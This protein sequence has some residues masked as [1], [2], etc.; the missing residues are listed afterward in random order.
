MR[1]K[2]LALVA[3][4]ATLLV[5]VALISLAR[6]GVVVNNH[7]VAIVSSIVNPC[8]GEVV[9]LSGSGHEVDRVTINGTTIHIG[10]HFDAGGVT[11][12]GATTGA[13]YSINDTFDV[14]LNV[15]VGA[16]E[17]VGARTSISSVRAARP[18]SCSTPSFMSPST[19]TGR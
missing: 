7:D 18:T 6:A 1:Y 5:T 10:T 12:V 3:V 17:S 9:N 16:N 11:G 19:P 14:S 2:N 13:K 15:A 4:S 8:N